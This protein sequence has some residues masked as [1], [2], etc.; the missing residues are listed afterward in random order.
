MIHIHHEIGL[1]ITLCFL[2]TAS[3]IRMY[4]TTF[5]TS[6]D[7]AYLRLSVLWLPRHVLFQFVATTATTPPT[8]TTTNHSYFKNWA[9]IP[10]LDAMSLTH[11]SSSYSSFPN[12]SQSKTLKTASKQ[13][14]L[15]HTPY[16][17]QQQQQQQ[18]RWMI[19]R[20]LVIIPPNPYF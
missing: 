19:P 5:G 20:Q 12:N 2:I 9:I 18:Y 10:I 16:I 14:P 13:Q 7:Y 3:M 4:R 15:Q 8:T 11:P 17:Q 1:F 6:G